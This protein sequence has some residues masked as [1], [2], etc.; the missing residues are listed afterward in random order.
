[1]ISFAKIIFIFYLPIKP[2]PVF[3]PSLVTFSYFTFWPTICPS[4][5]QVIYFNSLWFFFQG[6]SGASFSAKGKRSFNFAKLRPFKG[7][8]GEADEADGD[9]SASDAEGLQKTE[10]MIL[11][12]EAV[13][14]EELKY[15]RPVI[16]LGPLKDR[17]NDDL[18][19]EF[20]NEFGSCVPRKY[21][22]LVIF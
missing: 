5:S 11:S 15:T 4:I 1:M 8:R 3:F 20:P 13:C 2:H 19:Q 17:L 7:R 18:I 22:Y 12:Y 9:P 10:D 16:I 14:Q 6:G 21:P